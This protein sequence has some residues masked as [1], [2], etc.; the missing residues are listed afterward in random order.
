MA[1]AVQPN[2]PVYWL[3]GLLTGSESVR[4]VR[5]RTVLCKAFVNPK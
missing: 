1:C 5:K 4:F 2:E 3:D